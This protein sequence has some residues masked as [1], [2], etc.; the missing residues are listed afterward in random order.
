MILERRAIAA[1]V[2][3][4]WT[5]LAFLILAT[6]DTSF[7]VCLVFFSADFKACGQ[8]EREGRVE[9]GREGRRGT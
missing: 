4:Q 5:F 8:R 7:R 3:H 1:L 9:K 2:A 6:V